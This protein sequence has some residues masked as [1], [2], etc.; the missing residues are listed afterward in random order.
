MDS[1][2]EED[3]FDIHDKKKIRIKEFLVFKELDDERDNYTIKLFEK[4]KEQTLEALEFI[5][6]IIKNYPDMNSERIKGYLR[7]QRYFMKL[8]LKEVNREFS[9]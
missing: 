1:K 6:K 5:Q 9:E 7:R 8:F 4:T 3:P 2:K